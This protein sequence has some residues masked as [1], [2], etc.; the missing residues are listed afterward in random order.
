V[1]DIACYSTSRLCHRRWSSGGKYNI[2]IRKKKFIDQGGS[3]AYYGTWHVGKC[4]KGDMFKKRF[5]FLTGGII[6]WSF[7][8]FQ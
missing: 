3:N 5:V 1:G 4:T 6:I 8:G 7:Y 2:F